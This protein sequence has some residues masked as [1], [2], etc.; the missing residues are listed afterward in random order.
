MKLKL[1]LAGLIVLSATLSSSAWAD[2]V[3]NGTFSGCSGSTTSGNA[4]CPGWT[5]TPASSGTGLTFFDGTHPAAGFGAVVTFD[6]ELSQ[7]LNT[8]ALQEYAVSFTLNVGDTTQDQDFSV[9][10]GL[11]TPFF[12]SQVRGRHAAILSIRQ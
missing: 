11:G 12:P 4:T 9:Q 1:K 6:D 10:F 7:V 5:I 2:L 8:V 3:T